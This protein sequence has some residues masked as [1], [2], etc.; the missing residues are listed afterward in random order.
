MI[1][2]NTIK[3]GI[4]TFFQAA[5]GSFVA[6]SAD[7]IWGEVDI[8]KTIVGLLIT[9]VIAGLSAIAMNLEKEE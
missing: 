2:K 3:R 8:K 1:T 5:L 9:S 6:A 4:R 7:I